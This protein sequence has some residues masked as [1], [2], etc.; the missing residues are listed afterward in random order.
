LTL[1]EEGGNTGKEAEKEENAQHWIF[2][3]LLDPPKE[4]TPKRKMQSS[5]HVVNINIDLL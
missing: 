2:L 5:A 3:L 1:S 4:G